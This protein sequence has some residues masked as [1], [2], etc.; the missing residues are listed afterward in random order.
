M[1]LLRPDDIFGDTCL[2]VRLL[3]TPLQLPKKV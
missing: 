2:M 1:K 3:I